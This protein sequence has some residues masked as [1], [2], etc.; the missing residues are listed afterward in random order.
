METIIL[1]GGR[2]TRLS[3]ETHIK[4]KPMIHIGGKP[5]IWH[6]MNIYDTYGFKEFFIALGYKGEVIKEYFL[7]YCNMHS[8]LSISLKTGEINAYKKCPHDW[9]VHL[10]DTGSDTNTGGR[11]LR[12][13]KNLKGETFM[14]TYGDGI[15]NVHLKN[16]LKFHRSH[17]KIATITAIR[18]VARFGEVKFNVNEVVEFREKHQIEAG[19]INGGFFILEPSIFDYIKDDDTDFEQ[20]ILPRLAKDN[21]LMAYK[22]DGFWQCMDT[23]RDK[24]YLEGLWKKNNAPWKIWES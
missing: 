12:L 23:L 15:A 7:N 11:I 24:L 16:L 5:I 18:P 2:G 19:W 14:L 6:I 4:P 20:Q 8:D 1:A 22:H 9:K 21:Q 17:R 3:E 13:K 10:V